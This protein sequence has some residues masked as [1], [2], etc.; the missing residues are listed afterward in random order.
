MHNSTLDDIK[1]QLKLNPKLILLI[2]L[3][4][5]HHFLTDLKDLNLKNS[6]KSQCVSVLLMNS[7][8]MPKIGLDVQHR[9]HYVIWFDGGEFWNGETSAKLDKLFF[10][11][12][13]FMI[14]RFVK[15][16]PG[17]RIRL[18]SMEES[19]VRFV[20][21]LREKY[22]IEGPKS[23]DTECFTSKIQMKTVART[24]GS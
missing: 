15:I 22:A 19:L 5:R 1:N 13:D 24:Q 18:I 21:M 17:K 2:V 11:D 16:C 3:K 20:S 14:G 7:Y 8:F 10:P 6:D 9:F 12:I 23:V 4:G